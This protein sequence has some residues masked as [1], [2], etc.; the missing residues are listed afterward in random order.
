MGSSRRW[1]YFYELVLTLISLGNFIPNFLLI[2]GNRFLHTQTQLRGQ[3]KESI[4]QW[5]RA[6]SQLIS[7]QRKIHSQA[8]PS[9]VQKAGIVFLWTDWAQL[10][11]TEETQG[12]R[13]QHKYSFT[14]FPSKQRTALEVFITETLETW[15]D[16]L[17]Y[18]RSCPGTGFTARKAEIHH[19]ISRWNSSSR[20]PL[21]PTAPSLRMLHQDRSG[22]QAQFSHSGARETFPTGEEEFSTC[23][24]LPPLF[25]P[26]IC[27]ENAG[28]MDEFCWNHTLVYVGK[29]LQDSL[30]PPF[31]CSRL[32]QALSNPVQEHLEPIFPP[33]LLPWGHK[34]NLNLEILHFAAYGMLFSGPA[35]FHLQETF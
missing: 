24:G 3:F 2:S 14:I 4:D 23:F 28:W 21:H 15:K 1:N 11:W 10:H 7:H 32:L 6:E 35:L 26:Q 29:D 22:F 5:M 12:K 13:Q 33:Q 19:P 8:Q 25:P 34:H 16:R 17:S 20:L 18:S 9:K 27:W 31:H 30:F